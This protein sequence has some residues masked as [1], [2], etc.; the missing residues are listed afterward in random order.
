M[1]KRGSFSLPTS[2][3]LSDA[4]DS[5]AIRGLFFFFGLATSISLSGDSCMSRLISTSLSDDDG[6]VFFCYIVESIKWSYE[7]LRFCMC[8]ITGNFEI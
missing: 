1:F 7:F 6:S 8:N 2:L 5:L 4:D 3:S